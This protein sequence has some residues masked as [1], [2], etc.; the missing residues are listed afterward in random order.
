M[1]N[2][3]IAQYLN[4]FPEAGGWADP[5]ERGLPEKLEECVKANPQRFTDDLQ[6]FQGVRNRYQHS[7]L[8]GLL[9]AWRDK[10][11]FNW[12]ALLKFIHQILSSE[13]FWTESSEEPFNYRNRIISTIADLITEGTRDDKHAFDI[14]LLPITEKILLILAEKAKP[15]ATF[16]DLRFS[17]LDSVMGSVFPAMVNYAL[18][19]ARINSTEQGI[20]WTQAIRADFTKRLN[21]SVEP[22]FE[23][24]FTLGNYLPNLL[25]LDKEWVI[26]NI[27]H[28]FPRQDESHWEAAF[29]GYLFCPRISECLYSLLKKRGDY[30]KALNTDF[31]DQKILGKLIEHVCTGWIEDKEALDDK[32]SLIYQLINS[33]NPKLLSKVV[34][35]FWR[36]RYNTPDK[37]KSK[38]KPAWRALVKVLSQ[39]S[40]EAEYQEL[41]GSLSGWLGLVDR[42]DVE[43][44]EWLKLSAKYVRQRFNSAS[45]VEALREH[46]PQ[47]PREVGMIYLEMLNNKVYPDYAPTD[48]QETVRIL[49]NQGY[50]EEADKICNLYAAAGFDFL[51]SLYG[52]YQN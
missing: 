9:D 42:I 1:S 32:T 36:Q 16:I 39:N 24:S 41:L 44:L 21:R 18:R 37:V 48:I 46:V 50:K 27:D 38:V 26:N 43:V 2:A 22:S 31:A 20:R 52:E 12:D 19:Y 14:Q 10:R 23:F 15:S 6:P 45:F 40:S 35:F 28:I 8:S 7:I 49:Y 17:V 13:Q 51:R 34:H 47:T 33:D 30:Q 4:D 3:E 11:E 5:T 29:S 25:Y